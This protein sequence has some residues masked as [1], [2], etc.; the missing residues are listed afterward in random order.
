MRGK[1]AR[2]AA[3]DD[4]PSDVGSEIG[5]PQQT[6]K[7]GACQAGRLRNIGEAFAAALR[8][9]VAEVVRPGNQLDQLWVCFGSLT[10]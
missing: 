7:V 1:V 6:G 8:Q 10:R 5:Q 9:F 2:M 4:R 3:L